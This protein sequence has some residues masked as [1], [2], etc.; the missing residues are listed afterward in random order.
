MQ[1]HSNKKI[2]DYL[3]INKGVVAKLS[4]DLPQKG[5]NGEGYKTSHVSRFTPKIDMKREFLQH[6]KLTIPKKQ[7]RPLQA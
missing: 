4:M 7:T 6:T 3:A 1:D 5:F 2:Q